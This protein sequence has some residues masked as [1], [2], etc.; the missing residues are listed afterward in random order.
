[1][2][3]P[4]FYPVALAV[5][6]SCRVAPPP[7]PMSF[8]ALA[9]EEIRTLDRSLTPAA[10]RSVHPADFVKR[11]TAEDDERGAP[12]AYSEKI[13][14]IAG[15][16]RILRRAIFDV[17]QPPSSLAL[18]VDADSAR[19]VDT[20]CT[21]SAVWIQITVSSDSEGMRIASELRG[22]LPRFGLE[23]IPAAA[24]FGGSAGWKGVSKWQ[25]DSR[26]VIA[27]F[28]ASWPDQP[29][30]VIAFA[31]YPQ[32]AVNY[33][34]REE[35]RDRAEEAHPDSIPFD[36]WPVAFAGAKIAISSADSLKKYLALSMDS[37]DHSLRIAGIRE[38]T[39]R[40]AQGSPAT[41]AAAMLAAD[42]LVLVGLAPV[43]SVLARRYKEAGARYWQSE[44]GGYEFEYYHNFLD[45]A[46]L[47]APESPAGRFARLTQLRSGFNTAGGCQGGDDPFKRVSR[48]GIRFLESE[49]DPAVR[50]EV[51]FL[52]AD[53]YADIVALA[54]GAGSIYEDGKRFLPEVADARRNAIAHYRAGLAL[55]RKSKIAVEAWDSA[56]RLLAG[57]APART[58]FF[59]VYD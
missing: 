46:A 58:H 42:G 13:D 31:F 56:W 20:K 28:D 48:E 22:P 4:R 15:G 2:K 16:R 11:G 14:T 23:V 30:R 18:P 47:V 3:A 19:L 52:I 34:A 21:L 39:S 45:S 51:E 44:I 38:W 5:L 40:A 8:A 29:K 10:W 55:D 50:A 1:M 36:A 37:V 49:R 26:T 53:G 6:G 12:C 27:A 25:R 32:S 24:V 35:E 43:D 9:A 59:C 33:L 57:L 54:A 17:P 41:R 7:P